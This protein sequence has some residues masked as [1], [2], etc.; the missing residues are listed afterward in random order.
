MSRALDEDARRR[1]RLTG[2]PNE[3]ARLGGHK[4]TRMCAAAEPTHRPP[5][6]P[7]AIPARPARPCASLRSHRTILAAGVRA[8]RRGDLRHGRTSGADRLVGGGLVGRG[9]ANTS[10]VRDYMRWSWHVGQAS[11]LRHPHRRRVLLGPP[12]RDGRDGGG[13]SPSHARDAVAQQSSRAHHPVAE[14]HGCLDAYI[15]IA[16]RPYID[17]HSDTCVLTYLA[18]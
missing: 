6:T 4:L 5:V 1:R 18:K 7:R 11:L 3:P 13:L 12:R 9:R 17:D 8:P 14:P 10:G 16:S 2:A 15:F